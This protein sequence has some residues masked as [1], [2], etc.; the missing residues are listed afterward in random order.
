[1]LAAAVTVLLISCVNIAHL[2]FARSSARRCE[3]AVRRALGASDAR[4]FM[5]ALAD[6]VAIAVVGACGGLLASYGL[7]RIVQRSG[8]LDVPRIAE[9][10]IDG[11]VL[12][13]ALVVSLTSGVSSAI[14][15]AS[16]IVRDDVFGSLKSA[17]PRSKAAIPA[18]WVLVAV[19]IALS[20]AALIVAGVLLHSF[21]KIVGLDRGFDG[22][23]VVTTQLNLSDRRYATA[24]AR[25]AF[26]DRLLDHIETIPAAAHGTASRLPL[27][28]PVGGSLFSV[29]GTTTPRVE[30]PVVAIAVTDPGY[31]SAVGIPLV[32][33]RLF[34]ASDRE[35]RVAVVSAAVAERAWPGR[36]P[37]GR[38]FRLGPDTTPLVEVVGVVSNV[39]S[40]SLTAAPT[41]DVY[42]P[43]WQSD[44][45]LYSNRVALLVSSGSDQTGVAQSIRTSLRELDPQLPMP[46]TRTVDDIADASVAP[47]RFQRNIV[48]MMAVTAVLLATIGIYGVVAQTVA[49]RTLELGIRRALGA[50]DGAIEKEVVKQAIVPVAIGLIFGVAITLPLRVLLA[51]L[52]LGVSPLD[53][54]TIG[55]AAALVTCASL[56]AAYLPARRAMR[57]DPADVLRAS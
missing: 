37:V 25:V 32:R 29:E 19:E 14:L 11:R 46:A 21:L 7:L 12:I 56:L 17:S 15:P 47:F 51:K 45:S 5:D 6:A 39:R 30:R 43:Y 9:A 50:P 54:A 38:R 42:F 13:F 26:L 10:S 24:G 41:L 31:F 1:M 52:L 23:Q 53:P 34:A 55:I 22:R 33:G 27:S 2:L 4:L 49:E 20:S 48:L 35:S 36:D 28:G 18:R 57:L 8:S 40:V 3:I 44:M 16:R